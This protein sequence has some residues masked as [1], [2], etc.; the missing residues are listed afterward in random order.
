[1]MSQ[2]VILKTTKKKKEG[3]HI[4]TSI[5]R[6]GFKAE[7]VRQQDFQLR[8]IDGQPRQVDIRYSRSTNTVHDFR[9]RV[10]LR[11]N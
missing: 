7:A 6:K 3:T 10:K 1:M 11:T 4:F 2:Q 5:K 8:V 9:T